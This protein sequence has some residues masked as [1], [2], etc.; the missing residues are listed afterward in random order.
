MWVLILFVHVGALGNGNSNAITTQEFLAPET[1]QAA[2]TAAQK[3]VQN[4]VK[5]L[6]FVCIKK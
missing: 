2:G 4:T 1:C 3:L 5:E 6:S